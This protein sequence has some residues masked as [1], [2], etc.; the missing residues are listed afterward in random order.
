ML[1]AAEDAGLPPQAVTLQVAERVLVD[2]TGPVVAELAGCEPAASGSPST[3]SAPAT[4]RSA[5]CGGSPIDSIKIDPSFV[6]GLGGDPTLTL[7][8][9]AIAGL[10]RDLGIEVIATGIEAAEQAEL[11]KS[12]GCGLG[13]GNWIAGRCRRTRSTRPA[14]ALSRAGPVSSAGRLASPRGNS[15]PQGWGPGLQPGKLTAKIRAWGV[16]CESQ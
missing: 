6:A 12:M 16:L 11:L 3:A 9:S 2:G 7:L 15:K 10:G 1:G 5:T 13:Q 8:T 4:P 14:W